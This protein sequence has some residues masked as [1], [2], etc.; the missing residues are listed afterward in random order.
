LAQTIFPD[1]TEDYW[2]SPFIQGL[3]ERD[4]VAGYPDGEFKPLQPIKRDEFAAMLRQAFDRKQEREIPSGSIFED[5]PEN[6]WAEKAI[7]DAYETGFM[8]R[9]SE[10]TFSPDSPVS[11]AEAL[12][13][14][15]DGL[16]ITSSRR[17]L[18]NERI[19]NNK[20]IFPLASIVIMAPLMRL[21]M[22]LASTELMKK[23]PQTKSIDISALQTVNRYYQDA[24]SIPQN[25]VDKLAAATKKG[26]VVNYPN[27][28][29]LEPNQ[30][31]QRGTAA[32]LIYQTLVSIDR[33]PPLSP[34]TKAANYIISP[35]N[36]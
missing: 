26:I 17:D 11:K 8:Q 30:P 19:S 16:D 27:P 31:L 25:Q 33:L 21:G 7:A 29:Y 3:A 20:P 12:G 34:E 28:K 22:P 13:I 36:D 10:D 35:V 15:T 4:I 18:R 23:L 6:Y 1:I 14:L 5:V 32:A 2:A 24:N 9:T